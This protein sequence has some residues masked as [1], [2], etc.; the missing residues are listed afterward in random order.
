LLPPGQ[1]H[2]IAPHL[3]VSATAFDVQFS[4]RTGLNYTGVIQVRQVKLAKY[5]H[6]WRTK[7]DFSHIS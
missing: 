6:F 3:F 1:A 7:P 4:S 2:P 5:K